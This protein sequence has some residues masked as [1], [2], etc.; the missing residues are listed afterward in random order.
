[1]EPGWFYDSA[2]GCN[3]AATGSISGHF[4]DYGKTLSFPKWDATW[5]GPVSGGLASE[6]WE[7]YKKIF[8]IPFNEQ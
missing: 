3:E 6:W 5:N 1:M 2:P 8:K 7:K 4:S